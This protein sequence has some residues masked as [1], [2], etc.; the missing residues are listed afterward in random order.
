MTPDL[1]PLWEP[2]PLG[3]TTLKNRVS[4]AATTLLYGND[5]HLS[6]R[7]VAYYE[8]R[9]KGGVALQVTEEQAAHPHS[10]GG[11]VNAVSAWN[12]ESLPG[13]SAVASAVHEHGSAL[14]GQLFAS[15]I[16]DSGSLTL[17]WHPLWAAS[18]LPHPGIGE[19][20]L[21]MGQAEIDEIIAAFARSAENV[22]AAGLDGIELHG[23]HGWLIGQ[24]LSPFFNTRTDAYGGSTER[25]CRVAIEIGAA[26]KAV[27]GNRATVGLKLSMHEGLGT[28]GI[29]PEETLD[30]L[31]ILA[32]TNLFDYFSISNG[33][34]HDNGLVIPTMEVADAYLREFGKECKVAVAGR[35]AIILGHRI[36]DLATAAAVI[37]S[38][39]ADIVAMTRAHL[40]DPAIVR[41]TRD[42][43]TAE[44][45]RCAGENECI[46]RAAKA[47]PITCLMNPVAGRER[48]WGGPIRLATARRRIIVIGAGPAGLKAASRLG[49]RGHEVILFE[50]A[51]DPGGHLRILASLPHRL[52]WRQAL[53]DLIGPVTRT[54]CDLRLATA[55]TADLITS[56]EPDAVVCATGARWERTGVVTYRPDATT[57][58]GTDGANVL[59][60]GTAATRALTDANSLGRNVLLFDLSG[61]YLPIGLADHLSSAGVEVE[62]VTNQAVVGEY[63]VASQD[64]LTVFP[65]L[66]GAGV[67]L[68]P[69]HNLEA[70][71]HDGV[72]LASVW[73]GEPV[74]R[75]G[76]DTVVVSLLRSP[77]DALADELER[78]GLHVTRIGDA[79]VPRRTA[80]AIY[81][82][83][84]VGR[85]L[86]I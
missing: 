42:G 84:R 74:R 40:A 38:G 22:L 3:P 34:V 81:D 80:D 17:D 75:S 47:R 45:V 64:A 83:E 49:E 2:I 19:Q 23:A 33:G 4:V 52:G 46:V 73:G 30:Q 50:Q 31:G 44:I 59:D 54:G 71:F 57:I 26:V 15:G 6:D 14:F 13:L 62:V 51:A 24:F 79:L 1:E 77:N 76:I 68:T 53:D 12:P 25:N 28:A 72:E 32:E 82:G 43:R 67:R 16:K 58:P 86:F 29:T 18:R 9:A 37:R 35:A 63:V 7:H 78:L 36:R 27:C 60:L 11:F 8:E 48:Q 66:V 39:A 56:Q 41:K 21:P 20:A 65:R 5:G 55:A 61:E 70:I 85:E 10:H 69:Q